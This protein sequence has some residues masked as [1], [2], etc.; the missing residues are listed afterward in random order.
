MVDIHG[1]I[2]FCMIVQKPIA[3]L[4]FRDQFRVC[5][6]AP[7]KENIIKTRLFCAGAT[8]F[9]CAYG[10]CVSGAAAR[11]VA[12]MNSLINSIYMFGEFR[13]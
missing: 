4:W 2:A 6:R 5:V 10:Q 13:I 11:D 1:F 9:N 8:V 12:E 7:T 3:A